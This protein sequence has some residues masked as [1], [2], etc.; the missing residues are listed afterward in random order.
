MSQSLDDEAS[1]ALDRAPDSRTRIAIAV[2]RTGSRV[3]IGQ[4]PSH[5]HLAGYWEFPGGHVEAGESLVEAA[6]RE[7]WEETGLT[8]QS[9]GLLTESSVLD[10]DRDLQ[11]SFF[12]CIPVRHQP[13]KPPF[14]WIECAALSQFTFPPANQRALE[15]LSPRA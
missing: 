11:L 15:L 9:L 3:V 7:A 5:G 13:L 8:V 4:R 1:A 14:R 6:I 12:T 2:I 10:G